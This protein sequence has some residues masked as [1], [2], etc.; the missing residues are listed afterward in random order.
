MLVLN[1]NQ[2][3]FAGEAWDGV[4]SIA[5]DRVAE[6]VIA[7]RGE[8]GPEVVFADVPAARVNVRVVRELKES[9]M[10]APRLGQS[11]VLVFVASLGASDAEKRTISMQAVVTGVKHEVSARGATRMVE[12]VALSS[13][14]RTDPVGVS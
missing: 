2:V 8:G 12:L 5:V 9:D 3:V 1:P 7:E 13:D 6:E 10:S 14:G 4:R 11:A